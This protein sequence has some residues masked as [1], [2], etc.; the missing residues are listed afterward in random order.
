ML[1]YIAKRH[2]KSLPKFLTDGSLQ[3]YQDHEKKPF[4]RNP[5]KAGYTVITKIPK[6]NT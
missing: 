6:I 2:N 5:K 4:H 3:E 1:E